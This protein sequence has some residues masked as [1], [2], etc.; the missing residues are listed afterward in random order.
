VTSAQGVSVARVVP[1]G[2]AGDVTGA[3]PSLPAVHVKNVLVPLD[4]SELAL[5]AMPTARVL[6][7]RLGADLHTVTVADSEDDAE[8]ARALAS[9]ALG[10]PLAAGRVSVVTEGDPADVIAR[11]AGTLG[12]CVVCMATHGRGRLGG[13]LVG[14][15]AR[16]VLQRSDAP[17]IALGPSADNPGWSP[18]PRNW[19]E[20][21]SV[22]R[23][24]ACVDGSTTSEQVLP[25][26]AAWAQALDMSLTIVTV[27]ED[28][29]APIRPDRRQSR[30]SGHED[31][32]SYIEELVRHWRAQLPGT[33]G[34]VVRDPLG[35]ASGMRA[36]LD[37]RPAGLV[38]LTTHARSGMQRVVLG[39]AA[40]SIVHASV[41]PCLV[42]PVRP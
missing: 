4:G 8:R 35:P 9:A 37:Q 38:A 32:K 41:A 29:P 6:A 13:A 7:Q 33:D 18:R 34:E 21:L 5:Q 31:A 10:G 22:A 3:N 15:V 30:Y 42:A 16:S 14:S 19:P 23:I 24:V 39:A 20:P 12:S 1:V 25:L 36:H 26:A 11:R 28:A 17:V 27:I 40:A 2:N